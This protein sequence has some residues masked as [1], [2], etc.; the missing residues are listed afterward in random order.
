MLTREQFQKV[1]DQGPDTAF[2][3]IVTLQTTLDAQQ[4][5][6]AALTTRVKELEDRLGTDSHNSSK[7]PSSDGLAKKPV[8]LR[9]KTGRRSGGQKGHPGRKLEFAEKPDTTLVHRATQCDCCGEA[10]SEAPTTLMDRRQVFDLPP[11]RLL[12]TEHQTH[13]CVCPHCHTLNHGVF[14]DA[15]S[16]PVQ[17]GPSLLSLGV[18]LMEYQLLPYARTNQLLAD[19]FGSA[20]CE[21]TLANALATCHSNLADVETKIKEALVRARAVHVDETGIRVN[22]KLHW[23]HV[24]STDALTF[25]SPQEKRGRVAIDAIGLLNLLEGT[26]IHDAYPSY[27]SISGCYSLCNAHLLRELIGLWE[28]TPQTWMQRM[29]ALLVALHRAEKAAKEAG[30]TCLDEDYLQ[31]A[32]RLYDKIVERG[33]KENPPPENNAKRGKTKKS[34]AGNILERLNRHQA[35]IL[36]FAFDFSVPFD[37]NQAERDLRMVKVHQ[38]VSGCF[39]SVEGSK[40][41]CRIRGYLSTL[42][43]QGRDVLTALH[44]TFLGC[45]DIPQLTV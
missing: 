45:P 34:A 25:Y 43:K 19:L 6:I 39:R 1:Y 30:E 4:Q 17:Y 38:K 40:I 7:P 27:L 23:L 11:L 28:Q 2:A 5:Q 37:N 18:Y 10:L 36:R 21:G 35:A 32:V 24:A 8:S 29:I 42:R 13:A 33:L 44:N 31:R 41:F 15:V 16:Q 14:P 3:L 9:T 26:R 22:Q 20:P 12:V